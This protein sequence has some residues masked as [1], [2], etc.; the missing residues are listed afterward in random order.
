MEEKEK[1][2][3]RAPQEFPSRNQKIITEP[4][5]DVVENVTFPPKK[6]YIENIISKSQQG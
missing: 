2:N 4:I 6:E 5:V 1:Q 3:N